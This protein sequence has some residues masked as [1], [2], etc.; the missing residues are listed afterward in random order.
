MSTLLFEEGARIQ[1]TV[2]G[3]LPTGTRAS[4]N[5][6]LM[7][8]PGTLLTKSQSMFG[9]KR[10]RDAFD[11]MLAICQARDPDWLA[12]TIRQNCIEDRLEKL[13]CLLFDSRL[14]GNI[15]RYWSAANDTERWAEITQRIT[16]F[17]EESGIEEPAAPLKDARQ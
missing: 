16:S 14:R 9:V 3:T 13:W 5:V 8:E 15:A 4:V 7:T 6:P 11:V 1:T 17:L 2:E 10:A 12:D